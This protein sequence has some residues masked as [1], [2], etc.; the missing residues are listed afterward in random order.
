[1]IEEMFYLKKYF[2]SFRSKLKLSVLFRSVSVCVTA[3]EPFS[4]TLVLFHCLFVCVLFCFVFLL[5]EEFTFFF[6][7]FSTNNPINVRVYW[8]QGRVPVLYL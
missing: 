5:Y 3:A 7:S 6:L 4:F 8:L 2:S 1:M